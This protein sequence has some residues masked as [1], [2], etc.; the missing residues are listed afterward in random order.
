MHCCFTKVIYSLGSCK[1]TKKENMHPPKNIQYEKFTK[2]ICNE[3]DE[4]EK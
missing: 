1:S 4:E 3:L 2:S